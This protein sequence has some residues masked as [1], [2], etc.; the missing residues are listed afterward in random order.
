MTTAGTGEHPEPDE[1][2]AFAEGLLTPERGAKVNEHLAR[3]VLCAGVRDSLAEVRE[4]LGTLPGPAR[5][6]DDVASRIDAAL[7]AEALL[8][9]REPHDMAMLE[10]LAAERSTGT[11][12]SP[13]TAV[14]SPEPA[15]SDGTRVS[16]ETTPAS[17]RPAGRPNGASGP[18]RDPRGARR[19]WRVF[20]AVAAVA[21][22]G[23]TGLLT[24]EL[25]NGGD[26]PTVAGPRSAAAGT[27]S[28]VA[29][30]TKVHELLG[31]SSPQARSNAATGG[32]NSPFATKTPA[33]PSCVLKATGHPG[34]APVAASRGQYE[35]R[36]SYLVV[37]PDPADPRGRVDAY[38]VDAGCAAPGS[39]SNA[40]GTVLTRQ[41]YDRG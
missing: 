5:M 12:A 30:S 37:L 27:F 16:R 40:V 3:C 22:L 10:S 41:T 13:G 24:Q 14:D 15:V 38:V 9:V 2:S 36:P 35:S 11:T 4:L 34:T 17:V 18:G 29:L 31:G 20:T 21:A 28:G 25:G 33:V 32:E 23:L 26:H 8:G 39:A 6:P 19:R 1:I 7:A